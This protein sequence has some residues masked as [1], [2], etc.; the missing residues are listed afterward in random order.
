MAAF[1]CASIGWCGTKLRHKCGQAFEVP[2][3]VG[4]QESDELAADELETCV[5]CGR[6]ATVSLASDVT[7]AVVGHVGDDR[8]RVISTAVIDHDDLPP[9]ERLSAHA[10]DRRLCSVLACQ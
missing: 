7:N 1:D 4:V 6:D 8:C 2:L 9:V 3:V 5:L 10:G